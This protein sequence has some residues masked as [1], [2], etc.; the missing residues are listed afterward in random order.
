MDILAPVM[1][2]VPNA[3]YL[4]F[5]ANHYR[6][7]NTGPGWNSWINRLIQ[8]KKGVLPLPTEPSLGVELSPAVMPG[9]RSRSVVAIS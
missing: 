8:V 5:T 7:W 1:G 9:H 4:E 3:R 2:H 6:T